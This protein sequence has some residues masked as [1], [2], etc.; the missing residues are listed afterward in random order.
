MKNRA[1]AN[2]DELALAHSGGMELIRNI[3]MKVAASPTNVL[4]LG[5]PGAGKDVLAS[6]I[7]KL[8][9]RA[10]GPFV[11]LNC[12]GLP[13]KL[14]GTELFGI[15]KGA[16]MGP[17]E[18]K[19]GLLEAV[20]GGTLFLDEI[21][22]MPLSIQAEL[23]SAIETGD[24]KPARVPR[25]RSIDV[26]FISATTENIEAAV[27]A[28]TF[29]SDLMLRLSTVTLV[30]PP[31]RERRDEISALISIFLSQMCRAL[32][33][34]DTVSVSSE[35]MDLL[36]RYAWPG[37][38]RELKNTVERAAVLSAGAEILPEHL[39]LEKLRPT[40]GRSLN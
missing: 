3:A 26:R 40:A 33:R 1:T 21:G 39:P 12:A 17:P 32:G 24:V 31:L 13:A 37:N 2:P 23:L 8:S 27:K 20:R 19:V 18:P 30:V 16:F 10:T 22:S 5:E 11:A 35:A 6:T 15:G 29:R 28:R 7:H 14:L 34:D 25:P 9:P 38:I 4:I 36:R